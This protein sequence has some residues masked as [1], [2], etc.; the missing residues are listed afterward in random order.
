MAGTQ[1][2]VRLLRTR[3]ADFEAAFRALEQRRQLDAEEVGRVVSEIVD[4]VRRRG[5]DALLD[6]TERFD[7]YRL[8]QDEIVVSS[9]EISAGA[10]RLAPADRDALA[11]AAQRIQAFHSLRVPVSWRE[12]REGEVLGQLVRPLARVGLY[13]PAFKAPLASTVL[14]LGIPASVAGV[15]EVVMASPGREPHPAVLEAA[16]LASVTRMLRVGGAQAVAALA[17]GTESVPRVDKIVGPGNA[18]VQAAKRQVFGQVAID[19]EAGPSEVLIV[20]DENAPPA[21]VAAD[22]MAQAEHD[23]AASVVLVTPS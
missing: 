2:L 3:D 14:M 1:H 15:R 4:D 20:A 22:L 13:V 18:Y 10:A 17:F 5:D 21:F 11:S 9:Q 6:A 23:P 16:R 19:A 8:R 12:E 7:G